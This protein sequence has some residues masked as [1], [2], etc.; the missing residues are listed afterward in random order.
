LLWQESHHVTAAFDYTFLCP[1]KKYP[2]E[3]RESAK[4]RPFSFIDEVEEFAE[5]FII[6]DFGNRR[7][8]K[9]Q[10][11]ARQRKQDLWRN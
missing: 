3:V 10:C 5:L 9:V 4:T 1:P 8:R 2:R 11:R 7:N 6:G